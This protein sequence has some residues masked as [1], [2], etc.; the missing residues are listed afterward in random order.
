[1]NDSTPEARPQ[2]GFRRKL[3][4]FVASWSRWLHIYLSLFA[5]ATVLFFSVTGLTLNHPDWFFD[6]RTVEEQGQLDKAWLNVDTPAPAEWDEF[7]FG[8]QIA[9]LEV[10]E[11]LRSTHGLRGSVSDFLA[12]ETDCEVTFQSPGYAATARIDRGSGEYTVAVTANDLVSVFNDLHKGRHSGGAWSIVIDVSAILS[13]LVSVTG[14]LLIF[15]L[16]VRRFSG[17]VTSLVGT[18]AFAIMYAV[19]LS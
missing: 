9:K 19:A 4:R 7:D 17:L 16:K 3:H 1:M 18:I 2:S 5:F 12:F 15:Y 14:F 13:S 11:Y 8:H 6:E 10:A